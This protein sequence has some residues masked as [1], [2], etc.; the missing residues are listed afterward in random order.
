M[1]GYSY[2]SITDPL[3]GNVGLSD[4]EA[5]VVSAPSF[6]RLHNVRQLGLAHLVFPSAGYSRF[7]HSVGACHNAGRLY[8]AIC[9][10]STKAFDRDE[11]RT[12]RLAGL[13]HDI[14]HY[15]FSHATE[16]AVG[17]FYVEDSVIQPVDD[18]QLDIN[19][20]REIKRQGGF[21]EHEDVGGEII[22]HDGRLQKI[23]R[24]HGYDSD[25][26]LQVFKKG[27]DNKLVG[28]IS[29]E[30]DCDRLDYLAR[31]ARTAG[32]P[33]GV[34][35]VDF[36]IS[37]ATVDV[38]GVFCFE[39]KAAAAIDH[40]LLS[41]YFD[42]MQMVHHKTV[43][44][45]EWSL[46]KC[47]TAVLEEG[48]FSFNQQSVREMIATG[49]WASL[50][51]P[52]LIEHFKKLEQ[53]VANRPGM[54]VLKSHLASVL[55]RSPAKQVWYW[56]EFVPP[57]GSHH[58]RILSIAEAA[59]KRAATAMGLDPMRFTVEQVN[60]PITKTLPVRD[61]QERRLND[62]IQ[63]VNIL[64]KGKRKGRALVDNPAMI[65]RLLAGQFRSSISVFYLPMEGEPRELRDKIRKQMVAECGAIQ[66]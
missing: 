19:S 60:F 44:A 54:D 16:E 56:S 12:L 43:A 1:K 36:I 40:L 22:T 27:E 62:M 5:D 25:R 49:E 46:K 17:S 53:E 14:G 21:F 32:P 35:D 13:L 66:G 20:P 63:S 29:S 61:D 34:V 47:I 23:F 45:L 41:R 38:E 31:T 42:Y 9:E 18:G 6:Q 51:D 64:Y 11:Y 58:E 2:K 50:D 57:S 4:L 55:A 8:E 48:L 26:L 10:N 52:R 65:L 37:K 30:L 28:I 7:S 33:Y 59:V 39:G 24:D 3:Y 15:P